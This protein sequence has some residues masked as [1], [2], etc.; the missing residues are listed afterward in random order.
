MIDSNSLRK[1]W[2]E[3]VSSGNKKR[4]PILVEKMIRALYLLEQLQMSG[5]NFIFK[6]GTALSLLL[7][8]FGRLSIDVDII[9][10]EKP[11][12]S[13]YYFGSIVEN[14]DFTTYQESE[15]AWQS[16]ID[17]AHYKFFYVPVAQVKSE[18]EYIL[19]DIL[20]DNSPYWGNLNDLNIESSFV[21][22]SGENCRVIVPTL[23]AFLG[24]K[25]TAFAP[26]TT[27]VPYGKGKEMEII[28]QLYDIAKI[29][30]HVKSGQVVREVFNTV[31]IKELDY[32]ALT[33]YSTNDVLEDILDTALCIATRG[34]DGNGNYEELLNG[35]KR[36]QN[37]I[38]EGSFHIE[39]AMLT[40]AKAAYMASLIQAEMDELEKFPGPHVIEN[41]E[42]KSPFNTKLNKLKKT[43]P[44]AFFYWYKA[45]E[46]TG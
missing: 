26:N 36:V 23:E 15:R 29:F 16:N 17:K 14:S 31:A 45:Y 38:Y 19:L 28:K 9:M 46:L 2:I 34:N 12:N 7:N 32:R 22:T 39:K 43:S 20:Y 27:G 8:S 1:E 11:E 4:D 13:E 18:Q 41:W 5:A 40:A 37:F 6:G 44:E 42:I 25:L 3:A 21:H 33:S 10:E 35:I 30:D 24:D